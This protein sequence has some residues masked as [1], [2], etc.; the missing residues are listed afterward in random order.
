MLHGVLGK[1]LDRSIWVR[2]R[3]PTS[4]TWAIRSVGLASADWRYT[5][6]TRLHT[7][8]V[9]FRE[10][11]Y[12]TEILLPD[13]KSMIRYDMS[14]TSNRLT[15]ERKRQM[16]NIRTASDE[17]SDLS[18][19]ESLQRYWYIWLQA[20]VL[21]PW[22]QRFNLR[23]LGMTEGDTRSSRKPELFDSIGVYCSLRAVPSCT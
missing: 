16:R 5:M 20:E 14:L 17:T 12:R 1:R 15:M 19:P 3:P 21:S 9:R 6:N 8:R 13:F 4:G 22:F 18:L 11:C 7:S 23:V 10:A 2:F